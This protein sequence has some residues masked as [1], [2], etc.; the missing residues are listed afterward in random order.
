MDQPVG[1]R[2]GTASRDDLDLLAEAARLAA[3]AAPS[4]LVTVVASKGST[5]RH[6]PAKMIVGADGAAR[7]TIGGGRLEAEI[8]EAA[9]SVARSAAPPSRLRRA[10]RD[11]G[12]SCGGEIEVWIEPLDGARAEALLEVSRRLARRLPTALRTTLVA[13]GGKTALAEDPCLGTRRPR[14]EGDC[15]VEPA[16]PRDRLL[17]FGSGHVACALAALAASLGFEVVVCDDHELLSPERFPTAR[18]VNSLDV[19]SVLAAVGPFGRGD[20]AIIATRDHDLDQAVLEQLLPRHELA[21]LGLL[22][23]Q[24]KRERFRARVESRGIGDAA[25]FSRL[26]CPV[27][28]AIGAET[29]EEIAVSIVADLI[30]IRRGA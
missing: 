27:G 23:S 19:A 9:V 16:L 30:R 14:L 7:G 12:M 11:L 28:I 4:A 5:P 22:G 29:P 13:P 3:A 10:T 26:R 21:S 8:A 2:A 20:H 15:F 17:L 25:S 1:E 24:R 6:P 18:R